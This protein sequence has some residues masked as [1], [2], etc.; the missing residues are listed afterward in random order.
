MNDKDMTIVEEINIPPAE[1]FCALRGLFMPFLLSG[2]E[3]PWQRRFSLVGAEPFIVLRTVGGRTSARFRW[4][5]ETRSFKDPF[6]ACSEITA[7][8]GEEGIKELPFTGGAVG[9]FSYDLKGLIEPERFGA[10][11]MQRA[12]VTDPVKAGPSIPDCVLGF[13]DTV[14]VYDHAERKGRLASCSIDGLRRIKTLLKDPSPVLPALRPEAFPTVV[15]NF[16]RDEYIE[17]VKKVKDYIAAGDIYQINISQRFIVP[18]EGDPFGLYLNLDSA[19]FSSFL[20]LG[21]FQIISNSP[22]RL[23][24]VEADFAEISPIKGTRSRGAT[25]EEDRRMREELKRSVKER[26][27]HVMIVDLV[28]N[29]LGR[30][31]LPGTVEVTSFEAVK[32]FPGLHHMVSTVRGRLGGDIDGPACLKSIFPGGSVTGAPK[33]RAM[34]I[35]DEIEPTPRSVYTGAIGWIG[36]DGR[37]DMSMAIRT[38]VCMDGKI[39]L[40]AGGGIVADSDP[41]DEYEE[42]LLKARGFLDL[43]LSH[44]AAKR[45]C[46]VR[47]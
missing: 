35:I 22:E 40:H 4:N 21:D 18:Y 19:P 38:A 2:G 26:A 42:T 12:R 3:E 24:K 33:I 1:A 25:P 15:S 6:E 27:E 46:R 23:L 8:F 31:C 37:M 44:G 5:G 7:S 13:Y 39:H 47:T 41:G 36:F 34:E 32:T 28:R 17:A 9:Y 11:G 16:T 43:L 45:A 14:Y 29:D 30:V 20:D 10:A